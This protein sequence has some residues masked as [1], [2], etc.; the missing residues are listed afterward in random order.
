MTA[1]PDPASPEPRPFNLGD[2]RPGDD[3]MIQNAPDTGLRDIVD[4]I[5][6][7]DTSAGAVMVLQFR[8][9]DGQYIVGPGQRY[10]VVTHIPAPQPPS[11]TPG[12]VGTATV[13]GVQGVRVVF[14]GD[15]DGLPW[16]QLPTPETRQAYCADE[17]VTDFT[18]TDDPG[19]L[20]AQIES[21]E[22]HLRNAQADA[23]KGYRNGLRLD[24]VISE[25]NVLQQQRDD[26]L[27]RLA[28]L[29][30]EAVRVAV[31][32][33]AWI[34]DHQKDSMVRRVLAIV[35]PAAT[36]ADIEAMTPVKG[37]RACY[38]CRMVIDPAT[39][40]VCQR[41][42]DGAVLHLACAALLDDGKTAGSTIPD[43]HQV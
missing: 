2:I 14:T 25:A 37:T 16:W 31:Q 13:G 9:F 10:N 35:E 4:R 36:A 29:T 40:W 17:D 30:P 19:E 11:P 1:T 8:N 24:T 27:A 5:E 3:V 33:G 43:E 6:V 26:A 42:D 7:R 32:V 12:T 34:P 28:R 39:Q 20:R 15:A 18:P 22:H 38:S 21:L 23:A 41:P